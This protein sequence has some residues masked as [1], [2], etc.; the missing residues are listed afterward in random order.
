M[1]CH[2]NMVSGSDVLLDL[3][4][5]FSVSCF[6][7][8]AWDPAGF[9]PHHG[10]AAQRA[11]NDP[12]NQILLA[13]QQRLI[14]MVP[15]L[16]DWLVA[17][18]AM[19]GRQSLEERGVIVKDSATALVLDSSI[20]DDREDTTA[21][22]LGDMAVMDEPDT[23]T[24]SRALLFSPDAAS[25]RSDSAI[26]TSQQQ[27]QQALE[28][29]RLGSQGQGLF[30]VLH[31]DD[32]TTKLVLHEALRSMRSSAADRRRWEL[33]MT[34][35]EVWKYYG[36]L[37]VS[38][39]PQLDL[40][41]TIRALW[42]DGDTV[43]CTKVGDAVMAHAQSL[44]ARGLTVS[45]HTYT[46]L[47][48]ELRAMAILQ[49]LSVIA[50]SCDPLCQ[51]VAEA[52]RPHRHLV[53]WL[54]RAELSLT[55]RVTQAWYSL[56]LTLLAV[57][58]FKSHLSAAY[59]DTYRQVTAVY[60]QKGRGT[61]ER[62]GYTLSVQFLNRVTY[63]V[64]LV[65][66]HN[67]LL[68][69]GWALLE[70][71]QVASIC[72]ERN[73]R[74]VG[75]RLDPNHFCLTHRRYSPCISDLK[76]VLN[77]PGLPRRALCG[78]PVSSEEDSTTFMTL[79][80]ECLCLSQWMDPHAW[81]P[82]TTLV[83]SMDMDASERGWVGAFNA[84]ISLGSLFER[85]LGW[86][87]DDVDD[88]TKSLLTSAG[89]DTTAMDVGTPMSQRQT[90]VDVTVHVLVHG[91]APWQQSEL[92]SSYPVALSSLEDTALNPPSPALH[93]QCD[94]SLPMSTLAARFGASSAM[95][96]FPIAQTTSFSFHLP[97]HR[98]VASALREICLRP[99]DAEFGM[100]ALMNRLG[101]EGLP[102]SFWL[103]L[104][105][106]PTLILTRV[107]QIRAELWKRNGTG[108]VD[109]VLNYAEPPF[110]R[111][112]RDADIMVAQFAV[113][114]R[115]QDRW[116]TTESD[117]GI[118]M[119]FFTNLLLHRL[120]LFTAC[121][122]HSACIT[123][124]PEG[125]VAPSVP[126]SLVRDNEEDIDALKLTEEFLHLMILF[127]T[128]LPATIPSD[129]D[130]QILQARQRLHREVV[131]RLASGP[132]THSELSEVHH[133]LSHWDNVL[134]SEAGKEQ[135]PDDAT[136]AA[137]ESVLAD[138][139][140][141]RVSRGSGKPEPDTWEL[142]QEAWAE[143]DPSFYHCSTRNHQAAA[144][145]RPKPKG[146]ADGR[147]KPIPFAPEPPQAH[148]YFNRLR[149]DASVD[150][151]IIAVIYRLL[152]LHIGE[153]TSD[154]GTKSQLRG[155]SETA[156][157]RAIHFLTIS[158]YAWRSND[159]NFE[160]VQWR[161]YGGG[162]KGS[163]LYHLAFPPT[164]KEW[165]EACLLQSPADLLGDDVSGECAL[166]LL[167]RLSEPGGGKFSVEDVSVRA[168]AAWV[169][170]F[171]A[172]QSGKAASIVAPQQQ[173]TTVGDK[174]E[175]EL[176]KR[177]RIAKQKAMERMKAQ[178]AKFASLMEVDASEDGASEDGK[179]HPTA[180]SGPS[181]LH[182]KRTDSFGSVFS[183]NSSATGDNASESGASLSTDVRNLELS[184]APP[185]LLQSRPICIICNAE[186]EG[187][188]CVPVGRESD[189]TPQRKKSRRRAENVLGF[190]G[191]VQ[192]ST[193]MKGGGGLPSFQNSSLDLVGTHV[194]LCG[195][196][197]HYD[198]CENYLATVAHREDR[199]IG[200]REEFR[201]PLC[202]RLSNCLVPFIDVGVD[203][204][205]T[206]CQTIHRS[207]SLDT[208]LMETNWWVSRKSTGF[209]WDGHCAFIARNVLRGESVDE[210]PR[211]V[212]RRI[213]SLKKKDLYAAWNAMMRTP[214]FMRRK[215]RTP[216][217]SEDL[218]QAGETGEESAG[219]T[220]VW[221]KFMDQVTDTSSKADSRRMGAGNRFFEMM[222]EFRHV[223]V[224]KF[225][226]CESSNSMTDRDHKDVRIVDHVLIIFTTL[227]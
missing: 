139:A 93:D 11:A 108:L 214:R 99:N 145:H 16:I 199:A 40:S 221:R 10:P 116:S 131:H 182:P 167:H 104:M 201:C 130:G 39:T 200:K 68:Q 38:G 224:E 7:F 44:R 211:K 161:K 186:T 78:S 176:Q 69:L 160:A 101:E 219:E 29:G 111:T 43:A 138:I 8:T 226:Y 170:E 19:T 91:I 141:R 54:Q 133:V 159:P 4:F 183:S 107:G 36:V 98:F 21:S 132:K 102:E 127:V 202:Q 110:C 82:V 18:V 198:C 89:R 223:M 162:S 213:R 64:Q 103:G 126:F 79:W 28:L 119:A 129:K 125:E 71:F 46:E 81:R 149:R 97:L 96:Q 100:E 45:I 2:G 94:K 136:G 106:F 109:Q 41:D 50:T 6:V 76:C 34:V 181:A 177:K 169:C 142:K 23:G 88:E 208:F 114:G 185:R 179:D 163:L 86:R 56:L 70:T 156:L 62:S 51:T 37:I 155:R 216:A 157:A 60:A 47:L 26:A 75:Q 188:R 67:W 166:K 222:G 212:A 168:G 143:Y 209:A 30:L 83:D 22:T 158:A 152:L 227:I 72:I 33:D 153:K 113:L 218:A 85:L 118:G 187:D 122:F 42:H 205:D 184:Q 3:P 27:Q 1:V 112:L 58:T 225:A 55:A 35:A 204:I 124:L 74:R 192:A 77:V 191:Y 203:W 180:F 165:V 90:C 151:S 178:A 174:A 189:Q 135:H 59:C 121:G 128:E 61:L 13:W 134:L 24:P 154:S 105:E 92:E 9:C 210:H 117:D 195:H 175:T 146:Q 31:A 140:I 173:A 220:L 53:P 144:E 120:G 17:T 49:W 25:R 48:Q 14:A 63:V 80:L 73:E 95:V 65:L 150:S 197:V 52:I 190:V 217:Q 115:R 171:A 57:P 5:S 193:V 215:F 66:H 164:A 172:K 84:S 15:A 148:S 87:D 207:K 123:H 12:N 137:L 196:A 147:T 206:P 20:S 194:A 32:S